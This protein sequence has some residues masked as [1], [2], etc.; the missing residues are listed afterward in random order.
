MKVLMLVSTRGFFGAENAVLELSKQLI[1]FKYEPHIGILENSLGHHR[2][3]EEHAQKNNLIVKVFRCNG[4]FDISTVFGIRKYLKANHISLIHSQ[5]YKSNFY[6]FLSS[7][8]TATKKITTCH[9][10]LGKSAKMKFYK[11]L[12]KLLLNRFDKIV[13]VSDALKKEILESK[14][15][16]EKILVIDN[17]IDI[18]RFQ[19]A[20][21]IN[22]MR[23]S[24][25]I[26]DDEK[27]VGTVGRLIDEKGH[28]YLLKAAQE[29][30]RNYPKAKFI[31]VGDGHLRSN[32]ESIAK[33]L[34][35]ERNVIF[36]GIRREI[37]AIIHAMDIFVMP[38]L[39]E[40]LPFAILEAMAARRPV[41]A[42]NVGAIPKL[43]QDGHTGLLIEPADAAQLSD[44]IIKL[45]RDE[46]KA[47][48]LAGNAYEKVKKEFSAQ[49]MAEKYVAAYDS[50]RNE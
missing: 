3:L 36:T 42:S 43:I 5:G 35:L 33:E 12:D 29:V 15:P 38:S 50:I 21:G 39:N 26:E 7:L 10:W 41:I 17:G 40:G 49:K 16:S 4:K 47:D 1:A 30:L 13:A 37:P 6:S 23:K 2:A 44:S 27:T 48:L 19:P 20:S 46:K 14:I 22:G 32:L 18:D 25:G 28:E 11:Y 45:L 34:R 9:N 24:L 8:N 31:I